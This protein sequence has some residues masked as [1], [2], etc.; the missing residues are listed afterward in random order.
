MPTRFDALQSRRARAAGGDASSSS[1]SSSSSGSSSGSKGGKGGKGSGDGDNDATN[2]I[3]SNQNSWQEDLSSFR[4]D[5]EEVLTAVYGPD[6]ATA[7][8]VWGCARHSVA[9]RPPDVDPSRVGSFCTVVAQL[10]KKC[11]YAAP[12]LQLQDVVGLTLAE[13][14]ELLDRLRSVTRDCARRGTVG[15]CEVVQ[16]AEDY[17]LGHNRDPK[18]AAMS[19]WEQMRERE[20]AQAEAQRRRVAD[21]HQELKCVSDK[22]FLHKGKKKCESNDPWPAPCCRPKMT[23]DQRGVV[24]Q[25]Q[26]TVDE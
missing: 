3:V 6:F 14:A 17:L 2:A 18:R 23:P 11:P 10:G 21:A 4:A 8:G 20:E 19:A 15:M 24:R 1:S 5:E 26:L 25:T 13:Q 22:N 12:A 16:E 7:E 9:V